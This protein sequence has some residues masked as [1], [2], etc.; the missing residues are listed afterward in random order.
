MEEVVLSKDAF[1]KKNIFKER[2]QFVKV[3]E[4]NALMDLPEGKV[5]VFEVGQVSLGDYL[6]VRGEI[7]DRVRNLVQ[8]ILAATN[9]PKEVESEI[10]RVMEKER[11]SEIVYRVEILKKG[12]K[13][14]KLNESDIMFLCDKFPGVVNRLFDTIVDLTNKGADLKKNSQD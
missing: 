14:P 5:A 7:N 11:P 6:S 12:I 13:N 2:T 3:P 1:N 9:D 10:K 4:L 8:G